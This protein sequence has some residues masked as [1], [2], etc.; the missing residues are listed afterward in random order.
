MAE[1]TGSGGLIDNLENQAIISVGSQFGCR[2][3]K[4]LGLTALRG[5]PKRLLTAGAQV[6]PNLE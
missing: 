6:P 5:G 4:A 2:R 3:G 1:I